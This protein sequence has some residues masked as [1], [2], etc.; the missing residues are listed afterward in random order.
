MAK[1]SAEMT[2]A[3]SRMR[4]VILTNRAMDKVGIFNPYFASVS[5][6]DDELRRSQHPELEDCD[7]ENDKLQV[8]PEVVRDLLF[9]LDP[10][11]S[12]GCDGI[13]LRIHKELA[14]VITRPL[15]MIFEQSW[16]SGEVKECKKG[17]PGSYR[18]VSLIQVP[19]RLCR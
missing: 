13:H 4:M 11:K 1:G 3:C 16:E 15:L 6:T 7:C 18:P 8:N 17:D 14:D 12:K 5:N 19:V 10:Y 9:Q 2:S